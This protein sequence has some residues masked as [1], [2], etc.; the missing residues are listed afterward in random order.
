MHENYRIFRAPYYA[1]LS[2]NIPSNVNPLFISKEK[3]VKAYLTSFFETKL[4]LL[5]VEKIYLHLAVE[6]RLVRLLT[7]PYGNAPVL[8]PWS[9]LYVY[10]CLG[11]PV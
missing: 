1:V 4:L 8:C 11:N 5:W 3:S 6:K 9:Q 10:L 2:T 7:K